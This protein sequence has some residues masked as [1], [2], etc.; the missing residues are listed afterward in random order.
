MSYH[1]ISYHIFFF[2][3]LS[4][5]GSSNCFGRAEM[6]YASGGLPADA[7]Q[8]SASNLPQ[9]CSK[10]YYIILRTKLFFFPLLRWP[11]DAQGDGRSAL[12]H[13]SAGSVK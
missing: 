2:V 1:I 13:I 4:E 12:L 5:R 9:P 10:L 3:A 7:R 11:A 6:K 8:N